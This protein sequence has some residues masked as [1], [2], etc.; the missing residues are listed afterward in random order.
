MGSLEPDIDESIRFLGAIHPN[1]PWIITRFQTG[2]ALKTR[3]FLPDEIGKVA[4]FIAEGQGVDNYYYQF[5]V[6]TPQS[7]H[8]AKAEKTDMEC[9]IGFQVDI[10]ADGDVPLQHELDR[11]L[12]AVKAHPIRPSITV[13]SGGGYQALWLLKEPFALNGDVARIAEIE[14]RN[15]VLGKDLGGDKTHNIDR[16]LRLPGTINVPDAKKKKKGRVLAVARIVSWS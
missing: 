2:R 6:R 4:A 7:L 8:K 16:I 11:I 13:Y 12:G 5:N 10:D 3:A 1:R 9:A 14:S 15:V